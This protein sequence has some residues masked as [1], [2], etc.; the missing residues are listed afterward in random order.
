MSTLAAPV[1]H[2]SKN[3]SMTNRGQNRTKTL[4]SFTI[5]DD[6]PIVV[7]LDPEC[8]NR[9]RAN[10]EVLDRRGLVWSEEQRNWLLLAPRP[11]TTQPIRSTTIDPSRP[12]REAHGYVVRL[13]LGGQAS[14]QVHQYH[15]R[16]ATSISTTIPPIPQIP[17][18]EEISRL[19]N[20]G[21]DGGGPTR[22]VNQYTELTSSLAPEDTN[23]GVELG[24]AADA[25]AADAAAVPEAPKKRKRD[26]FRDVFQGF[27]S[28]LSRRSR[29]NRDRG[30]GRRRAST[31]P[32]LGRGD[33]P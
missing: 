7:V 12:S 8:P 6:N 28:R 24:A 13:D 17:R 21:Q 2:N 20:S 15:A 29:E 25:D 9:R 27:T 10:T 23:L 1:N 5:H 31:M 3:P 30:S 14:S 32:S 16:S 33:Q 18:R 26:I 11:S 22:P 4:A 19:P